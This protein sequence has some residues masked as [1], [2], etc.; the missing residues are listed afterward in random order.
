MRF[1]HTM[2]HSKFPFHRKIDEWAPHRAGSPARA[3][4]KWQ[5]SRKNRT[6]PRHKLADPHTSI[7]CLILPARGR[8]ASPATLPFLAERPHP[9]IIRPALN[10]DPSQD[11]LP[12]SLDMHHAWRDDIPASPKPIPTPLHEASLPGSPI[13]CAFGPRFHP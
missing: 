1:A 5:A 6:R 8:M 13:P 7:Y 4:G 12:G 11:I 2:V 3:V 10:N 9:S